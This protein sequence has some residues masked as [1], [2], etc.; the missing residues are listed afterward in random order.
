[1]VDDLFRLA[2]LLLLPSR[3][4]GFGL[5]ILE[6]GASRLPIACSDLPTLREL[7]GDDALY[8][9]LDDDPAAIASRI[10]DRLEADPARRLARRV[11][12]DYAWEQIY[13][14]RIAPLL[15]G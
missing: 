13:R 10:R 9:G 3:D 11:R 6:A 8:F 4:E 12:L 1:M 2:D 15:E 5:P 14:T 7:A